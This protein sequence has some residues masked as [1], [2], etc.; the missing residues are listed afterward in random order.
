MKQCGI[1]KITNKINNNYYI[2]SSIDINNR[3][4]NHIKAVKNNSSYPIH[5]A[6]RKYGV[7]N[8]NFEIIELCDKNELLHK[9]QLLLDEHV[10]KTVC[11]NASKDV[12]APMR[13]RKHTSK[14]KNQIKDKKKNIPESIRFLL[15]TSWR[16]KK[17]PKSMVEKRA[18]SI[19]GRK[20]SE[21][22]KKKLSNVAKNRYDTEGFEFPALINVKTGQIIP[23]GKNVRRMCKENNLPHIQVG[24]LVSGN[25]KTSYGWRIL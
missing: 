11:Y 16:G 9:E 2:G 21:E 7:E 8:F 5:R 24:E 10:G 14:T 3:W 19:R 22:H 12:Y 18:A 13:G 17:Q 4:K 15:G 25:R 23:A 6:I 20:Y 1:Y